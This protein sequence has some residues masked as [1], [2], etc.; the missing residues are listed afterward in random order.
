MGLDGSKDIQSVKSAC[1]V[2]HTEVKAHVLP[3]LQREKMNVKWIHAHTHK[4]TQLTLW[5]KGERRQFFIVFCI[6]LF[7]L[8]HLVSQLDLR[9]FILGYTCISATNIYK[10]SSESLCVVYNHVINLFLINLHTLYSSLMHNMQWIFL[11]ISLNLLSI[12]QHALRLYGLLWTPK[13]KFSNMDII[14]F[15]FSPAYTRIFYVAFWTTLGIIVCSIAFVLVESLFTIRIF[16]W[17]A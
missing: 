14:F 17:I 15:N 8:L 4:N 13:N 16:P 1:A 10:T 7:F 11:H 3:S 6:A 5:N 2:L 12:H 9:N